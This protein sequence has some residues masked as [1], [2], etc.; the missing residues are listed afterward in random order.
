MTTNIGTVD[1]IVRF[2]IGI[3]LIAL[4]AGYVPGY[5]A[6]L[7]AWIGLVPLL[8]AAFGTCPVYTV[9]GVSTCGHKTT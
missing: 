6:Q 3:A 7:W 1:R 8:T 5:P 4:A 2:I 9:L